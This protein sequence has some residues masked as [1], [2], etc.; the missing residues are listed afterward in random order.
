MNE[1][2]AGIP[3]PLPFSP[4][5]ITGRIWT[6]WALI[7]IA[8]SVLIVQSAGYRHRAR[9][10]TQLAN[11]Q[12]I[13]ISRYSVGT[14]LMLEGTSGRSQATLAGMAASVR[15]SAVTPL[16]QFC[17]IPVVAELEGRDAGWQAARQF[18]RRPPSPDL[19][20]D[21]KVLEESYAPGA[22]AADAQDLHRLEQRYG[23]YGELAV[24]Q[25]D[26]TDVAARAA[27]EFAA[28]RTV[29]TGILMLVLT[30]ILLV[31][32]IVLL[33]LFLFPRKGSKLPDR[34]G[35]CDP[36][37]ADALLEGFAVYLCLMAVLA[38]IASLLPSH[39]PGMGLLVVVPVLAALAWL[40]ARGAW[41]R[42]LADAI[43]WN[44]G[45]GFAREI[46]AGIVGY[47]AGIPVMAVGMG[48]ALALAR[49]SST[50]ASH[51]I[52]FDIT[53]G[54]WV[55][56][57]LIF[58]ACLFAPVTEEL[59]FRGM[60]L[61][62]LTLRWPRMWSAVVVSLV[63]AAIHPQGWTAIPLLGGVGLV[64]ALIRIRRGSLVASMT[65]HALNNALVLIMLICV[66][67]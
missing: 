1:A 45:R 33:A 37:V 38:T 51:P 44:A 6:A 26:T 22:A 10:Q 57:V 34:Y 41:G 58:L 21:A 56:V 60:L 59:M 16:D 43:G 20:I 27:A 36:S 19:V 39:H 17:I 61:R 65:A 54:G 8:A 55:R 23:W 3:P 35:P 66:A 11:L 13:V 31:L 48:L 12:M 64:L 32:G 29:V 24:S 67:G 52:E 15:E 9:T 2:Q 62:H 47:V 7:L 25:I 40:R 53:T 30:A 18:V 42:H 14:K 63:F 5:R 49:L 4:P 46:F 28:K 50:R